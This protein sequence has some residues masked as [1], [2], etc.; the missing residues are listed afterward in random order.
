MERAIRSQCFWLQ[1]G[2]LYSRA[3]RVGRLDQFHPGAALLRIG[4]GPV[5]HLDGHG[6]GRGLEPLGAERHLAGVGAG[7]GVLGHLHRHP[8][9]DD[10]AEDRRRRAGDLEAAIVHR[11]AV[12]GNLLRARSRR[13]PG[14][15]WGRPGTAAPRCSRGW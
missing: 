4:D 9:R 7:L 11:L 15:A 5:E 10:R 6:D 8:D 1:R 12:D 2:T 13:A 14:T 3:E